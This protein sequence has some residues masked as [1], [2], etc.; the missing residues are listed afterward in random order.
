M[1]S[2]A[3]IQ[4]TRRALADLTDEEFI[5]G[6][7]EPHQTKHERKGRR[8]MAIVLPE[9]ARRLR[10]AA[11]LSKCEYVC[12]AG[13]DTGNECVETCPDCGLLMVMTTAP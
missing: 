3:A 7:L 1:R 12:P 6:Y 13:C 2:R 9:A 10:N 4:K 8:M 5:A 11:P